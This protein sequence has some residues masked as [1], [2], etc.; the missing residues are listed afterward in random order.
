[1][2]DALTKLNEYITDGTPADIRERYA[3]L[4][5][6]AAVSDFGRL[7]EDVVVLDTET[8]GFS[9]NHDELTQIAAARMKRGR[10]V[11]WFVKIGRAHV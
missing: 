2:S 8:T 7:D 4:K 3:S 11:E 5:E 1:M 10:I 6:Y 9:Q